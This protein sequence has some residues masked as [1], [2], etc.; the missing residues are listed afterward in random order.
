MRWKEMKNLPSPPCR[1]LLRILQLVSRRWWLHTFLTAP[2]LTRE[3]RSLSALDH[4]RRDRL[5]FL[6]LFFAR[7]SNYC[8]MTTTMENPQRILHVFSPRF[9]REFLYPRLFFFSFRF[10]QP[11][12]RAF[13]GFFAGFSRLLANLVYHVRPTDCRRAPIVW[14]ESVR[15]FESKRIRP[16]PAGNRRSRDRPTN[17]RVR[18]LRSLRVAS[19]SRTRSPVSSTRRTAV[20]HARRYFAPSGFRILPHTHPCNWLASKRYTWHW[21]ICS[22]SYIWYSKLIYFIKDLVET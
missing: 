1:I 18:D 2:V 20:E 3:D 19:P 6:F 21:E 11:R 8:T 12:V 17:S 10:C 14:R 16:K 4:E 9:C 7:S 15:A 13:R 5:D 22:F